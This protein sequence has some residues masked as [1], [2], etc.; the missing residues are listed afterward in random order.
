MLDAPTL[1]DGASKT[2][3]LSESA[4]SSSEEE[5][6]SPPRPLRPYSAPPRRPEPWPPHAAALPNLKVPDSDA[7]TDVTL[8]RAL[9]NLKFRHALRIASTQRP[10]QGLAQ[11]CTFTLEAPFY[12]YT[13]LRYLYNYIYLYS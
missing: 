10:G 3:M 9:S 12:M 4:V 13:C 5:D 7:G 11:V 8:L 6:I 2:S 1:L